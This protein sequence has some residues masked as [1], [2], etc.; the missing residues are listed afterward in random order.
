MTLW[1]E[2]DGETY[3]PARD[4]D[5]LGRQMSAVRALMG[6]GEWRN[7]RE[8]ATLTG[9]PE[10]SVSARLRDLRKPSF[11][12]YLVDR[13][14]VAQGEHIYRMRCWCGLFVGHP[15]AHR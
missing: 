15:G 13:E 2:F 5:R 7:L 3:D 9:H 12:G 14:Y 1:P 4:H 10:A 6:D 8:I 11:G